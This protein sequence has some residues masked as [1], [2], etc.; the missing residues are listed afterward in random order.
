[1]AKRTV[2]PHSLLR[3]ARC[4]GSV[5]ALLLAVFIVGCAAPFGVAAYTPYAAVDWSDAAHA[6]ASAASKEVAKSFAIE[7]FGDDAL[8]RAAT[9]LAR[10]AAAQS[11]PRFPD[12]D[13]RM[14]LGNA[15]GV[16]EHQAAEM[17]D[18]FEATTD[19]AA[20]EQA[21]LVR[22]ITHFGPDRAPGVPLA[23]GVGSAMSAWGTPPSGTQRY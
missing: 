8:T 20:A 17:L 23:F 9:R 10:I 4:I 16:I 22:W 13:S 19:V 12:Q 3:A 1:M 6:P 21:A 18:T 7:A 5:V 11:E 2:L 15:E 14:L